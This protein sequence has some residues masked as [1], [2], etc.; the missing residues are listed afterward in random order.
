MGGGALRM[1]RHVSLL[2]RAEDLDPRHF[3]DGVPDGALRH[4]GIYRV[5][6][7]E[8]VLRLY[9]LQR[10]LGR[11]ANLLWTRSEGRGAARVL[12]A[13]FSYYGCRVSFGS[14]EIDLRGYIDP[15]VYR[16]QFSQFYPGSPD[17]EHV[18]YFVGSA[19]ESFGLFPAHIPE[20][21]SAGI[22][23]AALGRLGV[24]LPAVPVDIPEFEATRFFTVPTPTVPASAAQQ[25]AGRETRRS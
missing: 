17:I 23:I 12:R 18:Q 20:S 9:S 16:K 19:W 14:S 6:P 15:R 21:A 7:L 25:V 11:V 22:A 24:S 1:T 5:F 8:S 13:S 3:S 2:Y 4:M 10:R